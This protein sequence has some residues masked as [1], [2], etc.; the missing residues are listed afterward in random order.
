MRRYHAE[1]SPVTTGRTVICV[2]GA[3]GAPYVEGVAQLLAGLG[4]E[5]SFLFS[6][7]GRKVF[8][9][10]TGS[11]PE[12]LVKKLGGARRKVRLLRNDDLFADVA[13]GGNRC[14]VLVCPCSAGTL[15]RVA[16]GVSSTLIERVCDVALKER[17]RLVM[18][19]RESP[20]SAIHLRNMQL[21]TEAGAIVMPASPFFYLKPASLDDLTS[22]FC[23]RIVQELVPGWSAGR[24]WGGA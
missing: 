3:S 9:Y 7:N 15:G 8:E 2:T 4:Q 5:L 24:R 17:S 23:E 16:S 12:Q 6:D 14:N 21:V 18:V 19:L 20:L 1:E 22:Q 10:E 13:S 11:A